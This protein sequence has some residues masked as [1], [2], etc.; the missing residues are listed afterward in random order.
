MSDG[1]GNSDRRA[2]VKVAQG[3]IARL[4]TLYDALA[5]LLAT[6]G[7]YGVTAYA[8]ARRTSEI[9]I[10]MAL[11]AQRLDV[12]AMVIR[13]ASAQVGIGLAIGLPLAL[14]ASRLLSHQLYGIS[15]HDP[16]TLGA[17]SIVLVASGILAALMPARHAASVDPVVAL[18]NE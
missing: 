11:G 15:G 7:L 14:A 3:R 8:I 2:S 18:R 17:A 16:V 12:M 13:R 10:R 5:L 4:T 1:R 6:V 9:G